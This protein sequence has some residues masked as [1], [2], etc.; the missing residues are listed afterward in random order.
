MENYFIVGLLVIVL[1]IFS[2]F[3]WRYLQFFKK[4]AKSAKEILEKEN[5][6][7]LDAKIEIIKYMAIAVISVAAFFGYSKYTDLLDRYDKMEATVEKFERLN[8]D[9]DSLMVISQTLQ[10]ELQQI[11]TYKTTIKNQLINQNQKIEQATKRIPEANVRILTKQLVLTNM[12]TIGVRSLQISEPNQ[13]TINNELNK[14][15]EILKQAGFTETEIN[16]VISELKKEYSWI[17]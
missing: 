5:Y 9:Y 15:I 8:K 4:S 1:L 11:E 14:S 17:K 6:Y 10:T 16:Q 3:N 7:K 12:R 2:L 13:E